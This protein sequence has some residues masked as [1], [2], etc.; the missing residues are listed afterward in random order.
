MGYI[1]FPFLTTALAALHLFHI[2]QRTHY[3]HL[4]GNRSR[5]CFTM[6]Q[7]NLKIYPK[8]IQIGQFYNFSFMERFNWDT[9][10]L[11]L[12][13]FIFHFLWASPCLITRDAC[14]ETNRVSRSS[15]SRARESGFRPSVSFNNFE[16]VAQP[17]RNSGSS[18]TKL[19]N[20]SVNS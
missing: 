9:R 19:G 15:D 17:P 12:A 4:Y 16:K 2:W 5:N 14:D 13:W 1:C 3:L 20:N 18:T 10:G 11:N 6:L 8:R 7:Y